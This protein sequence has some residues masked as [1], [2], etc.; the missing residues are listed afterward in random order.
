MFASNIGKK[1]F[2]IPISHETSFSKLAGTRNQPERERVIFR[3]VALEL[4]SSLG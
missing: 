3:L 1:A 4:R 2:S